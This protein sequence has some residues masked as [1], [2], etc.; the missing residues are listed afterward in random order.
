MKNR[1]FCISGI[2]ILLLTI[3]TFS[4][5]GATLIC[6]DANGNGLV[7][8]SD[9]SYIIDALYRNGPAPVSWNVV[10]VDNSGKCNLLDISY[11]L[12]WL[13]RDGLA[14]V[15]PDDGPAGGLIDH[16][17]CKSH[18]NIAT[19][20]ASADNM[21]GIYYYYDGSGML[22]FTHN[23]A[24]FNCCPVIA[25]IVTIEG[26]NIIVEELDSLDQGGCTCLCLFDLNYRISNL[27]PGIYHMKVIEPYVK[28]YMDQLEFDLD[29]SHET[30]SFYFV[31]RYEY[32][33]IQ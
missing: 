14:L 24:G 13:Y 33:W 20:N 18:T 16:G 3:P 19:S 25:S 22:S 7:N 17:G 5:S 30:T 6:G 9:I 23:N 31:L 10:D 8:L 12:S 32:P 28:D 29:L 15:C 2:L 26:N 11:M 1:L 21:D 4:P 27:P